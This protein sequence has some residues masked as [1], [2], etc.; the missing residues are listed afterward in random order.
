MSSDE[1]S[2]NPANSG[3]QNICKQAKAIEE[4][5]PDGGP[6]NGKFSREYS[7]KELLSTRRRKLESLVKTDIGAD[8]IFTTKIRTNYDDFCSA[9]KLKID[10]DSCDNV[11]N[12]NETEYK[13]DIDDE[14][15]EKFWKFNDGEVCLH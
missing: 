1:D 10:E 6:E 9:K 5:Y 13:N 12:N 2:S 7:S 11:K 3:Q 8:N 15:E 4:D 14:K